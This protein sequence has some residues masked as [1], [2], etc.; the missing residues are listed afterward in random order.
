ME[1]V[2]LT[3]LRFEG[4]RFRDAGAPGFPLDAVTELARYERLII[5]VARGLWKHEHPDR[6]RA[7]RRFDDGLRLR[8]TAVR[9]GSVIPVLERDERV[10][11]R[12]FDPDPWLQKSA[13]VIVDALAAVA[14]G[15][16]MPGEF[17]TGARDALIMFGAGLREDEVCVLDS[18]ARGVRYTQEAR[19]HLVAITSPEEILIDGDLVGVI[20][21]FETDRQEFFF[22]HRGG[23]HVVGRYSQHS[24]FEN[25]KASAA[26]EPEA[27]FVKL[28]C[29]YTT[30]ETGQLSEVRDLGRVETV[31][32]RQEPF[33]QSLRDLLR[34]EDGWLDGE[35]VR[36]TITAIEWARDF[37]AEAA[38]ESRADLHVFPS[39]E[40]GVLVEQQIG[41]A[42]WSLEVEASGEAFAVVLRAPGDI[43]HR[44][45]SD[46][47]DAAELFREFLNDVSA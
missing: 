36:P 2:A 25:I 3:P 12:L 34:L 6:Q 29:S 37:L 16:P 10:E 18:P 4:G 24:L 35:G 39:V 40:G 45:P 11:S 1:P 47:V 32:T 22:T 28:I 33:S 31:V 20:T 14:D 43:T 19:R 27:P 9:T 15:Q 44:E 30:D 8:L 41:S 17:P 21:G 46:P 13:D 23:R 7:P 38:G 5:E 42:R 26:P